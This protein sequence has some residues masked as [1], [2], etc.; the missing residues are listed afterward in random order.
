MEIS[1]N[2]NSDIMN[3]GDSIYLNEGKEPIL[4]PMPNNTAD[5]KE[6]EVGD[7]DSTLPEQ[8][9]EHG[10]LSGL[11]LAAVMLSLT[12]GAFLMLLDSS[13]IATA[14]PRITGQFH[15]LDDVGW[16]GTAYLTANCA[17]QPLT[18]KVYSHFNVKWSYLVFFALFEVGSALCGGANSSKML[19][20]GRAIAGLGA[21][22]LLNGSYT[23]IA[24][25][26]PVAKQPSYRGILMGL[27][28][29]G[30][31]A[32]PL[33]GGALTQYASWRWCFLINLP[34]G[35][36]VALFLLVVPIPDYRIAGDRKQT[37]IQRLGRLDF[38]GF[39]L[40]T[41]ATIMLIFALQWGGSKFAWGSATIIG[42][43]CGSFGN[44]LV[45]L[46]WE[47]R[48]GDEAM[49]P[50]SLIRRRIIWSSCLNMACFVGCAFT[51]TY[52]FPI[53]FQAVRDASPTQSGVDMLPQIITNMILT[54]VT[55]ALVGRVG[56]YMPFA[57]ASGVFTA[58]GSGLITTVTPTSSVAHR[59][60]YQIIQGGQGFGFQIPILAVQ[61]GVRKKEISVAAAL[62]VFSQNLSGAV[63]LSLA[64]VIF[65][66]QL[67]HEL[68]IYA[69]GVD[70]D[71]VVA[72]GASAADV[73]AAVAPA[74]LPGVL[75]AYSKTFNHV[76]Y[77]ATG[78]ACGAF[79]SATGMGWVRL[80][81]EDTSPP[82]AET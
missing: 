71:A 33:V 4:S 73:R 82:A 45:F 27:S 48:L 20:V 47:H 35:V 61:N 24:S 29:F 30:L 78:A 76:M 3:T 58:L 39:L 23:I 40:F 54:I 79:L 8:G 1:E 68:G 63:F 11:R 56:Y 49:I 5:S 43:F 42:L 34:C 62:V 75:L 44:L 21:S 14:I 10:Y 2:S 80:R 69:Q 72:A 32:G 37:V 15:S 67:K 31:L 12:L 64:E 17:F 55:G 16:Y 25:I 7:T 28:F 65:N 59:I 22:G 60:G 36:I 74:F 57:L 18:G 52:Y 81:K 41:P 66:N 51:T 13:I 46:L 9:E 38:I 50:L 53:Y 6:G 77:L 70:A 19:I 26:L